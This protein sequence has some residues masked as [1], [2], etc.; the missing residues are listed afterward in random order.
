MLEYVGHAALQLDALR[1]PV[2]P[3]RVPDRLL[4]RHGRVQRGVRIL[5]DDL[6]LA[7]DAAQLALGHARDLAAVEE[8]ALRR[9][10]D[11]AEQ[12][13]PERRLAAAGL[14]DEPEHL[15]LVEVERHVVDRLHVA[16][17]APDEPSGRSFP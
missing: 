15:A 1:D 9:S 8:H 13:P 7:P 3:Q 14:A 16:R 5:E 4:D 12:R 2:D 10:P 6:H 17:L 11:E